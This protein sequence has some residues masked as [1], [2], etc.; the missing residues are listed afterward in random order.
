MRRYFK[1]YIFFSLYSVL[2]RIATYFFIIILVNKDNLSKEH[3]KNNVRIF[4]RCK[5]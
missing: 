2:T 1:N 5:E 4:R 3:K